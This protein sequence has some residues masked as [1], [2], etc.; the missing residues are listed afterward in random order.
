MIHTSAIISPKAQLH[1]SVEVGPFSIIED[2][3]V[4]GEGSQI[5]SHVLLA[6]GARIGKNV[7]I[8]QGAVIGTVPQDLKFEGEM[9]LANIGDNTI[10]REYATINRGT[11]ESGSSDVGQNCMLMAY[12]HVAHDCKIGDNVIMANSVNLAG[13]IHIDDYA[14]IGGIVPV[15]QFVHIGAHSMIGGGFR[16]PQDVCPYSLLGGY[17][18]KVIGLNIIGLRRRGFARE[19]IGVLQTVFKHLFF[20]NLNTRQAVARILDSVE[21]T[22][23]VNVILKFIEESSGRGLIK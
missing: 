12:S 16:V 15:H 7:R 6:E 3:V 23:E 22:P 2:D 20:S 19:A 17:P 21:K 1:E 8:F 13:H 5:A 18:L 11:S 14:I 9:T 4:V 10:V